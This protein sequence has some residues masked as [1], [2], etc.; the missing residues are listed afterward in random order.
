MDPGGDQQEEMQDKPPPKAVLFVCTSNA[1]RSPMAQGLMQR[2]FGPIVRVES[3]GVR[4]GDMPDF[5]AVEAMDE[6]G[7]DL[8][9]FRPRGFDDLDEDAHFDLVISLSPEAHHRVL[10][11]VPQ[12]A[13]EAE[14]W[15]TYDPSVSEGNREQRM[16]EYRGVRDMLDQ[17]IAKRFP[18]QSFGKGGT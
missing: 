12:L 4:P 11:L 7:V 16:M 18:K 14:Y 5:L 10:N 2:R 13:D 15:P 8:A 9:K 1:I 3:V 6:F 17:R